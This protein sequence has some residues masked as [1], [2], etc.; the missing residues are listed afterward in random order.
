MRPSLVGWERNWGLPGRAPRVL[1]AGAYPAPD[2]GRI[3]SQPLRALAPGPP[4]PGPGSLFPRRK[5]DQ[6]A[7]GDTPAPGLSNRTPSDLLL[8]CH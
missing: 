8:P 4:R 7:A 5:S 1:I 3:R 2:P 6:N